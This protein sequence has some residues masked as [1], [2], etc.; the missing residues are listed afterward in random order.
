MSNSKQVETK[1]NNRKDL[2]TKKNLETKKDLDKYII[3]Q[4]KYFIRVA[5]KKGYKEYWVVIKA[6]DKFNKHILKKNILW[7]LSSGTHIPKKEILVYTKKLAIEGVN[8]RY[9][10]VIDKAE[11]IDRTPK[12]SMTVQEREL[13]LIEQ[14]EKHKSGYINE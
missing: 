7:V 11:G 4:I 14:H 2:E 8:N 5:K 10:D 9:T 12:K 13:F 6:W 1:F 3:D